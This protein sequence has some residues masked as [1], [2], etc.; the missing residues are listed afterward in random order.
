MIM[1]R[2]LYDIIGSY[3]VLFIIRNPFDWVKSQYLFR[4]STGEQRACQG[5]ES[6]SSL[7]F[8]RQVIGSD[9]S[10]LWY[11]ALTD[12]YSKYC[13][14]NLH[15]LPYELL[16][17][18]KNKF[19]NK[20]SEITNVDA[21]YFLEKLSI[22]PDKRRHK[23]SMNNQQKLLF[24]K[25][26]VYDNKGFDYFVLSVLDLVFKQDLPFTNED[27]DRLDKLKD[28]SNNQR[29]HIYEWAFKLGR[30]WSFTSNEAEISFTQKLRTRLNNLAIRQLQ[31]L[32]SN[33][34]FSLA[35]YG[36]NESFYTRSN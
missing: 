32:K 2:R 5:F 23:P 29:E 28:S 27:Y 9:V 34:N 18:D 20:L 36:L 19:S 17:L 3:D 31:N 24:E 13:G 1:A 22:K 25:I 4:L 14:G 12:C 21:S 33:H 6:W 7:H 30:S 8:G 16:K 10:E 35:D 15:I 11:S 26:G